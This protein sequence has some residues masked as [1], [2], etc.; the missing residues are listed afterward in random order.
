MKIADYQ[1]F[2]A[3]G[4]AE[5]VRTKAVSPGELL[6][7]AISLIEALDP[8]L[9]S[10]V[11]RHFDLAL[12]AI[13]NGLPDGP[14]SGVPF[15]IK[16]TG[17][18][19][20]DMILSTGSKLFAD[21][22]SGRDGTLAARYKAAGLVILGKSNTPE[23]ALSFATEPAAFGVSRNPWNTDHGP[24]GSSGG[25]AAAVAAG[26]VP[27]ANAS[28]GA[29]STRLPASHCGLFGFKPSRMRNPL[30]PVAVEGIA[31]M[32]TPHALSWSVRDNAA[33]LDA[34]AGPDI[35]DPYAAPAPAS[36]FLA[37][38]GRDPRPLRIGVTLA[39]PLGTPVDPDILSTVEAAARFLEHLGH[40]VDPVDDAGYDAH[41]LKAA[42]R[43]IAG[44]NVA[45]A[46]LARGRQLGLADP[47]TE[48]EA[49]NA[50]WVREGL[51]RS[52]VEYLSAVNQLHQTARSLGRFFERYDVL[53]SPVT[54]ELAA[55][56]GEMASSHGDLDSFYDRFWSHGPFTCA[57]NAS[58]FPAMSVPFGRSQ[59]GLPI[60][61]HF[62]AAFGDEELLFSLAGQIERARPWF[63]CR[64]QSL[65][66]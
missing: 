65:P 55:V 5:L 23:F 59:S 11:H 15:L 26:I 4:L 47:V 51:E 50:Q 24:G 44:V 58:G 32:S 33:L 45:P 14:F 8:V 64:P 57:F 1:S 37:A 31:G 38:A 2:D 16:N 19:V 10:V 34:S 28:D 63:H 62:G 17:F 60:G 41:A 56:I 6:E 30:G 48:L 12:A 29:G 42:W 43:V 13:R 40:H 21:A 18:D 7:T 35:G 39:S 20:K 52:G 66:V 22:V 46:V 36:S 27:M 9:N 3:L 53:L 61:V 54:G 25:S 49:V